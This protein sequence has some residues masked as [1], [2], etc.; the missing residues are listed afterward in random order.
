MWSFLEETNATM[1]KAP[2]PEDAGCSTLGDGKKGPGHLFS[3]FVHLLA[4]C[5]NPTIFSYFFGLKLLKIVTLFL[6]SSISNL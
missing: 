2:Q 6:T 1:P 4:C 5:D 3:Q